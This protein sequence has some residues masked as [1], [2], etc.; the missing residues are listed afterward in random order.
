[1]LNMC[2][3]LGTNTFQVKKACTPSVTD[4][5]NPCPG[6]YVIKPKYQALHGRLAYLRWGGCA[7]PESF[8]ECVDAALESLLLDN[9]FKVIHIDI[10]HNINKG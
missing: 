6:T 8:L 4:G 7:S 1:M 10:M 3:S 5:L 2:A 9:P